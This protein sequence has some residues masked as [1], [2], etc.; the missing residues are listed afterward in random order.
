ML[1]ALSIQ[2]VILID[3][4]SIEFRKGLCAL[5]GE[6]G[7]G[8][9][10]LLD[11]L[12]LALGARSESGLVRKGAE[13][14]QVTAEFHV[15][16][17]HPALKILNDAG[18]A[19]DTT[20]ILRRSVGADGRSRAFINDQPVSVTLLREI[21]DTLVEIHGQF[22]T[23]GLLNPATHRALLDEYAGLG[24]ETAE[25]WN[26][27]RRTQDELA[28][29]KAQTEKSRAE[30]DYLRQAVE[31]LDA[32]DPQAG[33]EDKLAGLRERLMH[34][35]QVLEGLS[36]AHAALNAEDDPVRRA[37]SIIDRI[38]TKL[39]DQAGALNETLSRAT[40]EVQDAI[41][42]I[43]SLSADL[44]ES[45]HSLETIDDR[46]FALRAQGRKHQCTVDDLPAVRNT[47]AAQLNLI[48]HGD[49]ALAAKMKEVEKTRAA[50]EK[51]A[52]KSSA[53]RKK[54]AEK[55]DK[56]V[57]KELPPLKLDKA[58]FVT[59]VETL[60]ETEWGPHGLDRVRFLVATNPGAEPGP[61]NKIAS[62]GE[63]ARFMLALKVVMAEVGAAGSL[64]FDEVDTGI[65]GS[66]ADAVGE[67]LVRLGADKQVLVVTHAPQVAARAGHHYIV[68]KSGAKEVKTNIVHL[69]GA[70][71]RE[72]IAR[73]LAGATITEEARKAADKLLET[74]T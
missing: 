69:D 25:L 46:L 58:K 64:V 18:L 39:G 28:A 55:L 72:E 66:T 29:L 9:S 4:L 42:Q 41:A 43:E 6:T 10:I 26:D 5:T 68:Q 24:P 47:L 67:R 45:E 19:G 15:A 8:K 71:R 20:L 13:T 48:E 50:F 65:G 30:E 14:A 21:G 1:A 70:K 7:A 73:M 37:W 31:D 12:G 35:E 53:Q 38:S 23:H 22:D 60:P 51:E 2:N 17:N 57:Q 44:Q 33:E 40:A 49:K 62:G 11:S 27:W 32:L 63:M 3:Q 74:G 56:L 61:L 36:A 59:R 54:S 16:K 34:R 52:L